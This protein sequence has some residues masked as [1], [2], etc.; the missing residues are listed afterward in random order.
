MA[1]MV[2]MPQMGV[3]EESAILAQWLVKEGEPVKEGQA[4]FSLETGKSAFE[5]LSEHNAVMLKQFFPEGEEVT[6]GVPVCALGE[7]GEKVDAPSGSAET[8][9]AATDAPAAA[10]EIAP[11]AAAAEIPET[12]ASATKLDGDRVKASP[13]AR[14]TAETMGVNVAAA[15]P[16]GPDGRIL[17]RDVKTLAAKGI[18]DLP[19][20][21]VKPAEAKA[22]EQKPA[23]IEFEEKPLSKI[24]KVIAENMHKSLSEMAQLTLN[25]S[26][27]ATDIMAFRKK[28]K[29]AKDLGLDGIT[30]NDFILYAVTRTL[31]EYPELNAH[32]IDN[33]M[34]L[35]KHV[36]LGVAVDTPRG[37]MVPVL[38]NADQM[39]LLE[40]SNAVK[41]KAAA[42]RAGD[43]SPDELTGSSFTISN[44]GAA[45]IESFTP[46]INPPQTGILGVGTLV[47]RPKEV[48]GEIKFYQAMNLSLTIDHRAIDGAPGAQFLKALAAKLE[49]FTLMLAK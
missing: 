2:L 35:F 25:R 41:A 27:D 29:A 49:N 8:T 33:K 39:S 30:L 19:V 42:C 3:S 48:D 5:C 10:A 6:V 20:A 17:E 31:A 22:A 28:A 44:I 23:E 34:R 9:A 47:L 14:M 36:H 24:R 40:L 37:L 7:P 18:V 13:R 15:T 46:V 32:L 38:H 26:F 1:H 45:G 21:E 11:A 43:I 4:L 12:T 16:T